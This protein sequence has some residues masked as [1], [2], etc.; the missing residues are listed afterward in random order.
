[1]RLRSIVD[2]MGIHVLSVITISHFKC[3][4]RQVLVGL[5]GHYRLQPVLLTL[6]FNM[7]SRLKVRCKFTF[8]SIVGMSNAYLVHCES[9]ITGTLLLFSCREALSTI[10]Y[11]PCY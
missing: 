3:S 9:M 6:T 8:R 2:V 7:I 11:S 10:F 4:C 5:N 1:M